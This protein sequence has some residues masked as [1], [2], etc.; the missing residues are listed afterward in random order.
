MYLKLYFLIAVLL[1]LS[2][3]CSNTHTESE[4]NAS[5][6]STA[7]ESAPQTEKPLIEETPPAPKPIPPSE[8]SVETKSK[9]IANREIP[10]T[11]TTN[12]TEEQKIEKQVIISKVDTGGPT[13]VTIP[14]P[15]PQVEPIPPQK[16]LPNHN[17]W[18]K[19]T[20]NHISASG[21]V[22]YKGIKAD[23][24][25]LDAYLDNLQTNPPQTNWTRK[26]KMAYWINAYN[27][28][29]IKLIVDN[30]PISSIMELYNGKPWDV[31][32]IK[33]GAQTYS[34]NNI[35]HDILRPRFKDPRIHFAVNCA[36]KSCPPMIN[37][38]WTAA[39]LNSLLDKQTR[40]F[41]NN[42]TFNTISSEKVEISK[43]FE[44][45][46][47]DFGNLIEYLNQYSRISIPKEAEVTYKTYD[48]ALNN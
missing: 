10:K 15:I 21:K 18:H 22:N 39:N 11:P 4:S 48:W 9:V 23:Q 5:N 26:E 33:L 42:S 34:L 16:S 37:Q 17:A 27:A 28:F 14:K 13:K 20:Q 45:Y 24:D 30:Y 38:A 36:A 7:T 2:F 6:V 32:W 25:Q 35:E 41:I 46:A 44:W 29:T 8:P 12:A 3:G 47:E 43:I 1:I 31:K 19:I 40:T